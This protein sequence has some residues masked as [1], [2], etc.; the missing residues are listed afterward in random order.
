[1]LKNNCVKPKA[2]KIK[3]STCNLINATRRIGKIYKNHFFLK[4]YKYARKLIPKKINESLPIATDQKFLPNYQTKK[5]R[6]G[7]NRLSQQHYLTYRSN[8]QK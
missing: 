4:K 5:V 8:I 7:N 6:D 3:N 1:M 2:S